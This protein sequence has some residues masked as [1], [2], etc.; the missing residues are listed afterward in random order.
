[1]V[2]VS[3]DCED[4]IDLKRFNDFMRRLRIIAYV[5]RF[6]YNCKKPLKRRIDV[7]SA[8][9]IREAQVI[10]G[11]IGSGRNGAGWKV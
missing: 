11:Q 4:V 5:R 1:M 6:I 8:Q 7:L 9:E 10:V 3:Y 2:S